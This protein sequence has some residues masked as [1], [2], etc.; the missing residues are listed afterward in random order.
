MHETAPRKLEL[1]F[2]SNFR[3]AV[4]N[5]GGAFCCAREAAR[6]RG[7]PSLLNRPVAGSTPS[8]SRYSAASVPSASRRRRSNHTPRLRSA[9]VSALGDGYRP[10]SCTTATS[11]RSRSSPCRA[12][13][14]RLPGHGFLVCGG[15][16][17]ILS[18]RHGEVI[19]DGRGRS[20][21]QSR[22]PGTGQAAPVHQHPLRL[23]RRNPRTLA[24]GLSCHPRLEQALANRRLPGRT[25]LYPLL[26]KPPTP[27]CP[28]R[29]AQRSK[30]WGTDDLCEKARMR[31]VWPEDSGT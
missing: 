28:R 23:R 8:P 26:L 24:T 4:H 12:D 5:D 19:A 14:G 22:D 6:P 31:N 1:N 20:P 29:I 7:R 18:P 21:G 15:K 17:R 11:S 13:P 2:Q 30:N 3:R 16:T 10:V 25:D 9:A 27:M